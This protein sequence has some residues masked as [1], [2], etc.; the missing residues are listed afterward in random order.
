MEFQECLRKQ[1]AIKELFSNCSTAE[2]RYEKIIKLGQELG[3]IEEVDLSPE[4]L[5]RGCQSR[6]YLYSEFREGKVYFQAESDA[7]ISAGLAMILLKVYSDE[8]P[9]TILKCHPAYLEALG[10]PGSLTPGR[11]IGLSSLHRTMQQHAIR[12]LAQTA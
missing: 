8:S 12:H 9:E 3:K 10:I 11:A 1:T 7:L 5:V 4:F 2:Q 6:L